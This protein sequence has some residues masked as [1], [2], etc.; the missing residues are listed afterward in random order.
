M[1]AT[2][3]QAYEQGWC[4]FPDVEE[5]LD[6]LADHRLG[7]ITNGQRD[8]QVTKLKRT[9][10]LHRFDCV[11]V[12]SDCGL[13]KPESAMFHH[14][15]SLA[16]VSSKQAVYVG[17]AYDV[18]ALAARRAGLVG[19][20]LDRSGTARGEHAPPVIGSLTDLP[21]LVRTLT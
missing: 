2:Y 6:A 9:G 1:F 15:C 7:V 20:W 4:L 16:D 5:C 14:A 3:I 13:P 12:P 8:Q 18:D 10:I 19:V 11:V 21:A 17:D